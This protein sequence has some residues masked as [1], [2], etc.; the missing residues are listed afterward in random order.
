MNKLII[1]AFFTIAL[2]SVNVFA[3]HIDN[4]KLDSAISFSDRLISNDSRL[5][6]QNVESFIAWSKGAIIF[7]KYY[8]GSKDSLHQIQSQTKSVV[9]LLMGIAIDKGFVKNENEPVYKYFPEYCRKEDTLKY[10]VTIKDLLSMS[11]G[12]EWEEMIPLDDPKNDNMNMYHSG[13]YLQYAVSRPMS[14]APYSQFKYNSGCPMIIAGII[15]KTSHLSLDKFAEKYLFTPLNIKE[16]NWIKDSTGFCHAGGGLFLKPSDMLKIGILVLNR[17]KWENAQ[18]VSEKWITKMTQS[19]FVT[20]F[21]NAGYGYF[22]WIK[23]L[24]TKNSNT[25]KMISAEGAGGQK[26]YIFRDYNLVISFTEHNYST[27]QVSPLFIK[28]SILPILE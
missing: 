25:T 4:A 5:F 17:G 16:Y 9:A 6:F 14:V 23:E 19:N 20:S 1:L 27:P 15:E 13:N 3:Q 10:A 11:A 8:H 24:K 22:W 28:E 21:E 18:M 26:V 2:L 7:E 12:F